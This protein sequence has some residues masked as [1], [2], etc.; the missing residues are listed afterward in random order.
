MQVKGGKTLRVGGKHRR[1]RGS[2]GHGRKVHVIAGDE[3]LHAV[4]AAPAQLIGDARGHRA[5]VF[6]RDF[7][8]AGRLPFL[9]EVAAL[10]AVTDRL[11]KPRGQLARGRIDGTDSQQ[12]YLEVKV[13]EALG[14]HA[15]RIRGHAPHGL[16]RGAHILLVASNHVALAG[17]GHIRLNNA[18][19]AQ[20]PHRFFQ[21]LHG[22]SKAIRGNRQ[23]NILR[24]LAHA[25]AVLRHGAGAGGGDHDGVAMRLHLLQRFYRNGFYLRNHKMRMNLLGQLQ[26]APGVLDIGDVAILRHLVRRR[27]R[28]R[29]HR[30]DLQAQVLEGHGQLLAQLARAQQQYLG[31]IAGQRRANMTGDLAW[32]IHEN[33]PSKPQ[34]A[35]FTALNY[36]IFRP[37]PHHLHAR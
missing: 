9:H 14:H 25:L 19:K 21:L 23:P 35:A 8:H 18:R 26:D 6:Q 31:G 5:G 17:G 28:I 22:A 33:A 24:H 7:A 4:H 36:F 12:G 37:Q 29:V 32:I 27:A 2:R 30:V 16:P 34:A 1:I 11:A 13:H 10:M 20:L 15:L 3:E